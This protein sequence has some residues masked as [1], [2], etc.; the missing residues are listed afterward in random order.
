[1]LRAKQIKAN[2]WCLDTG[3]IM[4]NYTAAFVLVANDSI[5]LFDCGVNDSVQPLLKQIKEIGFQPEQVQALCLTHAHLDHS[6][7]AGSLIQHLPNATIYAHADTIRHLVAPSNLEKGVRAVYGDAFFDN[8]YGVIY[9]LDEERCQVLQD[10]ESFYLEDKKIHACY[11]PGHAWHHHGF[12]CQED[13]VFFAGDAF[14]LYLK[15][16]NDLPCVYL[17]ST[18]PSQ[19]HPEQMLKSFD[20]I[21]QLGLESICVTHYGEVSDVARGVEV[22]KKLVAEVSEL[23]RKHYHLHDDALCDKWLRLCLQQLGDEVLVKND[24]FLRQLAIDFKTDAMLNVSGLR[25][26]MQKQLVD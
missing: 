18:P 2:V 6:G 16:H 12:Y 14:G 19:F 3:Y 24:D 20:R 5:A 13:S 10:G 15:A 11:T 23:I 7:G 22:L 26:W 25:Y 21:M 9:P 4:P 1:M 8:A 17:P